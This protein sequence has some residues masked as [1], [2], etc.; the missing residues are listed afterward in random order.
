MRLKS[1]CLMIVLGLTTSCMPS[2]FQINNG[3]K[4]LNVMFYPGSDILDDLLIIDGE[5]YFGKAQFQLDDPLGD[6]GFRMNNGQRVQAECSKVGKD[7]L[8]ED[9]CKEYTVYR[10][11]FALIPEGVRIPKPSLF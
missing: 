11:S 5:N 7:W 10:S 2:E 4:T 1:I 6:I 9:E 3:Q 8:D